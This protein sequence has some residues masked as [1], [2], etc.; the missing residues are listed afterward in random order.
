MKG[1][2]TLFVPVEDRPQVRSWNTVEE[3]VQSFGTQMIATYSTQITGIGIIAGDQDQPGTINHFGIKGDFVV[4]GVIGEFGPDT[5]I[6]S[7]EDHEI[8]GI[9]LSIEMGET[10]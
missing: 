3:I 6:R 10:E 7:L 8:F 5:T 1:I 9:K 2:K 4:L